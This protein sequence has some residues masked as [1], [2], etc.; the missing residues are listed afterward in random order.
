MPYTSELKLY[1]DR[2]WFDSTAKRTTIKTS[3]FRYL[4]QLNRKFLLYTYV[5]QN[6]VRRISLTI[7]T[8]IYF[9]FL[10]KQIVAIMWIM[11]ALK[12]HDDNQWFI[13]LL[14]LLIILVCIGE[15]WIE[16]MEKGQY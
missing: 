11:F 4:F 13:S 12:L 2:V 16:K 14:H 10:R 9:M 1:F 6:H 3:Q 5:C 7:D 15:L 8:F